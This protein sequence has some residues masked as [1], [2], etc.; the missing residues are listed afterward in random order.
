MK[1]IFNLK[2]A[3]EHMIRTLDDELNLKY[4]IDINERIANHQ[5]LKVGVI[6]DQVN[7]VSG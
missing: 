1:T 2:D 4:I 5:A 3:W 7:Y 6:R